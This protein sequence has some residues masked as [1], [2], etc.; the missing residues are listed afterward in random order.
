ME[1]PKPSLDTPPY[2]PPSFD[3]ETEAE[4]PRKDGENVADHLNGAFS[5][6]F[7]KHSQALPCHTIIFLS[8]SFVLIT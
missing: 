5:V 7:I 4:D 3:E 6:V 1:L 2:T 8:S